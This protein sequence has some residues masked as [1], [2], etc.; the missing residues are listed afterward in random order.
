[1][2]PTS[3]PHC[4]RGQQC[5]RVFDSSRVALTA[6]QK[7]SVN[8]RYKIRPTLAALAPMPGINGPPAAT[9]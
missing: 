2:V 1:M 4:Y 9:V 5:Q 6:L 8:R 3:K 7:L